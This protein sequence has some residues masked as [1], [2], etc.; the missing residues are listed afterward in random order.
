M[1]RWASGVTT[2]RQRPV[3]TPDR[4]GAFSNVHADGAEVVAEDVAELVGGH[5]AD[6]GGAPAEAGHAATWCWPPS[7]PT[8]RRR[9]PS[10]RRA[11]SARSASIRV[12]DPLTRPCSSRKSSS[13]W[14]ITSTRALPMPTTS[15]SCTAPTPTAIGTAERGAGTP[16]PARRRRRLTARPVRSTAVTND[17]Y[18]LRR[19]RHARRA[20]RPDARARSRRRPRSPARSTSTVD[21]H[22]ADRRAGAATP[23]SSRSTRPWVDG[24]TATPRRRRQARR[25]HRAPRRQPR[26]RA[27]TPGTGD[28]SHLGFRGILN[29]K[30][31]GFY[32]SHLHRRRRRRRRSSPPPRCRPPTAGGPSRAGTSRTSRPCFGVTLVVAD[33]LLAISNGPEVAAARRCRTARCASRSPTRCSMSTYLV[34]FVVGPLEATE[35]DRRRRHPA[36]RRARARQGAT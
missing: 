23:S 31:R 12:I 32:R 29:D 19:D 6:V 7:R 21:V 24:R 17:P 28:A 26:P 13:W 14:A 35:P 4:A 33:D 20:L 18:R 27:S 30:L 10:T 3:G 16:E 5:L 9:R 34:A 15:R 8:S 25:G 36:A 22:E 11:R 1:V 2:M